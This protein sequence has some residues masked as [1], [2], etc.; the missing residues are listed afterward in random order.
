MNGIGAHEV[1]I[2]TPD[3]NRSLA[4]LTP[5]EIT[6]VLIAYRARY[7]DLR[8]DFR[9]R[10]MVLFKNHGTR[11]GATLSPFP[12]PV[13]RRASHAAGGAIR[14]QGGAQLLQ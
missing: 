10:Y 5:N 12:Q 8:K 3:H 4:D 9:F 13:D 14:T 7:L 1:I 11:A 6:D 2:E